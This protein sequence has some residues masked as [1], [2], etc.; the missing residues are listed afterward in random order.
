MIAAT[1]SLKSFFRCDMV[2]LKINKIKTNN[3]ANHDLAKIH[4]LILHTV[5]PVTL[6]SKLKYLCVFLENL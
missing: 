5:S 3:Q 6:L 4:I 2:I 1:Q